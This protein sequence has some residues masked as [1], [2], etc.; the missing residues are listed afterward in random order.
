MRSMYNYE[1]S[2]CLSDNMFHIY[3]FLVDSVEWN[4]AVISKWY[5]DG[6][7]SA[8]CFVFIFINN[9]KCFALKY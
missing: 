2:L 4:T 5:D 1:F 8:G 9:N 6:F 7:H 3:S